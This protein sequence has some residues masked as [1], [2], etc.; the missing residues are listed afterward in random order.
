MVTEPQPI[1]IG[2]TERDAALTALGNHMRAGRLTPDEYSTRATQVSAA[3]THTDLNAVFVDLPGGGVV[4]P[5]RSTGMSGYPAAAPTYP[6][7]DGAIAANGPVDAG[8]SVSR[9]PDYNWMAIAGPASLILFFVCGFLFHGWG[10]AWL[11][12]LLP[13]LIGTIGRNARR[14]GSS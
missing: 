11:F 13:G 8:R 12:F 3:T 10:W 9:R 4:Q 1:R 7:D 2:N 14:P 5:A 6:T